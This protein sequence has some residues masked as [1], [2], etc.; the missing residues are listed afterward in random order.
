MYAQPVIPQK[1]AC[2]LF[3]VRLPTCPDTEEKT[4]KVRHEGFK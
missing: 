4:T 2:I 3:D 1:K